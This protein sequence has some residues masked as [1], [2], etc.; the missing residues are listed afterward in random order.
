MAARVNTSGAI[1]LTALAAHSLLTLTYG[2][3][4][5][6]LADT[7]GALTGLESTDFARQIVLDIRLPR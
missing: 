7:V 4:A 5:L 1:L 2:Q 3:I 6:P